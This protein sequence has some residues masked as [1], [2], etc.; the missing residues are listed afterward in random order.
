MHRY[1]RKKDKC[2][3]LKCRELYP[4][5]TGVGGDVI[6]KQSKNNTLRSH[7]YCIYVYI[8]KKIYIYMS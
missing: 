7:Y 1:D 5:K 6:H 3:N 4:Q 2:L 8:K